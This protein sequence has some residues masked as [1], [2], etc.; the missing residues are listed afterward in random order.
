MPFLPVMPVRK[1]CYVYNLRFALHHG[2]E[3]VIGSIPIGSTNNF[4]NL[5]NEQEKHDTLLM[6]WLPRCAFRSAFLDNSSHHVVVR[7]EKVL[8]NS[9]CKSRPRTGSLHLVAIEADVEVTKTLL[10][11]SV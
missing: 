5:A 3:E 10:V 4:N 8:V 11:P 7:R 6:R 1:C 2:M 9:G